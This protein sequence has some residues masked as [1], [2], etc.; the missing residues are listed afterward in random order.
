MTE[1]TRDDITKART[2]FE[3]DFDA[4]CRQ[5]EKIMAIADL[6][7]PTSPE[8]S[9]DWDAYNEAQIDLYDERFHCEVCL[10]RNVLE[11]V[12]PVVDAYLKTLEE[13]LGFI[14]EPA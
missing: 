11:V 12:F 10:V 9:E 6:P 4:A 1:F 13:A 5:A 2:K 7:E 14:D 8:G 3:Q